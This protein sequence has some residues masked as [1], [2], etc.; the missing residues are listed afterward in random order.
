MEVQ[1]DREPLQSI[2]NL[3]SWSESRWSRSI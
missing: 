1:F 2:G 3:Q